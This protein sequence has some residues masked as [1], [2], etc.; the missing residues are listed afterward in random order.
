M[1]ENPY[2]GVANYQSGLSGPYPSR[3]VRLAGLERAIQSAGEF[4][5]HLMRRDANGNFICRR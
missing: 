4:R 1:I 2:I 5:R 3:Y